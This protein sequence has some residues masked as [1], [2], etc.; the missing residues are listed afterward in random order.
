[1]S[2]RLVPIMHTLPRL[3]LRCA[4]AGALLCT[5]SAV[6]S[7]AL[8]SGDADGSSTSTSAAASA[9]DPAATA[10]PGDPPLSVAA[11]TTE[12][13]EQLH[14]DGHTDSAD[15]QKLLETINR[16]VAAHLVLSPGSG[17]E[18]AAAVSEAPLDGSGWRL[19]VFWAVDVPECDG[20]AS[21]LVA[22]R[23]SGEAAVRPVHLCGL[24][25]WEAWLARMNQ[26]REA[27]IA[28]AHDQDQARANALSSAWRSDVA[29]FVAEL[30]SFYHGTIPVL[31]PARTAVVLH[32]DHVPCFR[33]VSPKRRV[34]AL[35]GFTPGFPLLGWIGAC[36]AWEA[37]YD[38]R[39]GLP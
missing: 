34:H 18:G 29:E 11:L 2:R 30:A 4:W 9:S 38:R 25:H 33:L 15:L 14:P 22:V 10:A 6:A 26:R 1:M 28:A 7:A 5:E 17:A 8:P 24:H 19:W 12:V 21:A 27:L 20:L 16:Q 31:G 39:E 36:K 37:A 35:D 13:L 3:A 32:V 23:A